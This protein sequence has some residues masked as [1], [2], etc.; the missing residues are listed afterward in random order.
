MLECMLC[1][2]GDARYSSSMEFHTFEQV[3]HGCELVYIVPMT[4]R[5]TTRERTTLTNATVRCP[6]P[7]RYLV[8][9]PQLHN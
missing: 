6:E 3:E 2:L 1:W 8:G 9:V 5:L 7:T 4:G